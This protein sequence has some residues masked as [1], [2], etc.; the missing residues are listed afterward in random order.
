MNMKLT[1]YQARI[2]GCLLEKET[3]TPEQYPLSLNSLTNA[4]NQ[5]SNRE[6]VLCLEETTVQVVLDELTK[7][8][9]VVEKTGFG[10]RISKYQQ[11]FCNT[12][13]GN[14]QLT[15]QERAIVCV[16]L[17]R[18]PQTPGELR[19]RTARL[20]KFNDMQEIESVLQQLMQRPDG[21]YVCRLARVPG[22]REVRYAHLFADE[23]IQPDTVDNDGP[24]NNNISNSPIDSRID[25]LEQRLD[26]MQLEMEN[27]QQQIEVMKNA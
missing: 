21:P 6:P 22:K 24:P 9:L 26:K 5:K 2:I 7:A 14:V 18:G 15:E 4:C 8:R 25:A 12:E 27:L 10:S 3:T 20:A 11:R 1:Q 16:M 19:G 13:L 23:V 17:L